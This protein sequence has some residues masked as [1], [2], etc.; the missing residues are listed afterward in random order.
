MCEKDQVLTERECE[1]L[2]RRLRRRSPRTI[3]GSAHVVLR[4]QGCQVV[5]DPRGQ[6]IQIVLAAG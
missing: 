2:D 5:P 1:Q 4:D 3:C 6:D